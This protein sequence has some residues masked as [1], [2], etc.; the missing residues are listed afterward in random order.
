MACT[1]LHQATAGVKHAHDRGVV[2]RDIK[3]NNLCLV[4]DEESATLGMVKVLDFGL[5]KVLQDAAAHRFGTPAGFAMGTIG[6]MSPEQA[7]D[8][9]SVGIRADIFSLGRTLY[10]LL[11]GELPYRNGIQ[12]LMQEEAGQNPV[13]PLHQ[14]RPD[15]PDEVIALIEKMTAKQAK[16]RFESSPGGA[17]GFDLIVR[18][19]NRTP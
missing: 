15:I 14:L 1:L 4:R 6:Y 2:H 16:D 8:S 9:R 12:S 5:A 19:W 18:V 10:Y 7:T 13:V 3:P 17:G 11:S